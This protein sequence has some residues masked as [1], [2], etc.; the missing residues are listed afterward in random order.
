[1]VKGKK[2]RGS[3]QNGEGGGGEMQEVHGE[4]GKWMVSGKEEEE[5]RR[6]SEKHGE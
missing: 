3:G 2:G 1:M 6:G 4:R 5:R